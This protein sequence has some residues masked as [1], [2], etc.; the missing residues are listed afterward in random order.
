MVSSAE[1]QVH[2]LLLFKGPFSYEILQRVTLASPVGTGTLIPFVLVSVVA[3]G[4]L[5]HISAGAAGQS[6]IEPC[7]TTSRALE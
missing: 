4:P 3:F 6:M 1:P 7:T 2:V 5:F